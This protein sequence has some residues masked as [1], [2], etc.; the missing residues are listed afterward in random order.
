MYSGFLNYTRKALSAISVLKRENEKKKRGL[1]IFNTSRCKTRIKSFKCFD[2]EKKKSEKKIE[3]KKK[4]G[5]EGK[6][7]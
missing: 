1:V 4:N 2:E 7:E 5:E 6:E 3:K